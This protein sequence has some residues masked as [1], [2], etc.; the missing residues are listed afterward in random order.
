MLHG[1]LARD[2]DKH[3]QA[4]KKSNYDDMTLSQTVP[5]QYAGLCH[6]HSVPPLS[7]RAT[8]E[9]TKQIE[10]RRS[11]K[12]KC[13]FRSHCIKWNKPIQRDVHLGRT[14]K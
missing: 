5:E 13:Q 10:I 4:D 8:L 11:Q 3:V 12:H 1:S 7:L 14:L 2:T 9:L 6:A